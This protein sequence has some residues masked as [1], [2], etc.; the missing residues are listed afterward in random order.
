MATSHGKTLDQ[1]VTEA[2]Q[3]HLRRYVGEAHDQDKDPAWM[4]GFGLL[5]D[6]S[7]ENRRVLRRIEEEFEGPDS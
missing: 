4:A 5:A 2:V 7:I 6:L 3:E 1:F